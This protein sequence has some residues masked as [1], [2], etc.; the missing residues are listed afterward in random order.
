METETKEEEKLSYLDEIRKEKEELTKL[1]EELI[2][3]RSKIQDLK[4]EEILSG[5]TEAGKQA[6]DEKKVSPEDYAKAALQGK[7]VA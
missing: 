2:A 3:E 5:K 4:A 7:I 1:K 6:E